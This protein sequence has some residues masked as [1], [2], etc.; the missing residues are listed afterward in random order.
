VRKSLPRLS[1]VCFSR[2]PFIAETTLDFMDVS[3]PSAVDA[4]A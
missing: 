2:F 1:T 3:E 4:N